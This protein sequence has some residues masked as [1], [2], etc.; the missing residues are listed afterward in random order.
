M[1]LKREENGYSLGDF[2]LSL[3][4]QDDLECVRH[5]RNSEHVKKWLLSDGYITQKMHYDWFLNRS[6]RNDYV[7]YVK[8]QRVGLISIYAQDEIHKNCRIGYYIGDEQ[9]LQKGYGSILEFVTLEIVFQD[10]KLHRIWDFVLGD[11]QKVLNMH[12]RFGFE[13]EGIMRQHMF[14]NDKY[15]DIIIVGILC[16]SW[17]VR[18]DDIYNTLSQFYCFKSM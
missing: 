12:W 7:F 4:T 2:S 13:K 6:H 10:L 14:K 15:V 18:R 16:E 8:N 17:L 1:K 11:H 3:I 5:W 9:Y